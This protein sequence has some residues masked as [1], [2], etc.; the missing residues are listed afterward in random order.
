MSGMGGLEENDGCSFDKFGI[1]NFFILFY[2]VLFLIWLEIFF[3]K[4]KCVKKFVI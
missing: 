4:W 1:K 2:F 3:F